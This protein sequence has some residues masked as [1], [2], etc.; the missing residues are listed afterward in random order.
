MRGE[1]KE[2]RERNGLMNRGEIGMGEGKG[3]NGDDGEWE[4]KKRWEG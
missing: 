4:G 2:R 1:E 3:E